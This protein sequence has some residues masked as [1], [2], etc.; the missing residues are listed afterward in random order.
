[1]Q[2][3][4]LESGSIALAADTPGGRLQSFIRQLE[5]RAVRIVDRTWQRAAGEAIL[6]PEKESRR[7]DE[8]L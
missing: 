2:L 1:V 3:L 8:P 4:R 7:T 6:L 5:A